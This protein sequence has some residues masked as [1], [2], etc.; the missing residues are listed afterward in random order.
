MSQPV[1]RQYECILKR[2]ASRSDTG[3]LFVFSLNQAL[4]DNYFIRK[5]NNWRYTL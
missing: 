5:K 2:K 3:G 4:C 1:F